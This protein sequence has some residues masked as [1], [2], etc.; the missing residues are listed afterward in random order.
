MKYRMTEVGLQYKNG[1]IKRNKRKIWMV[2]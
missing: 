1:F 2:Q